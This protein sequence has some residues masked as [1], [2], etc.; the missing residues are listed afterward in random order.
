MSN[1]LINTLL[2]IGGTWLLA[3]PI[4]CA[5]GWLV[6]RVEWPGRRVATAG[7]VFVLLL[8]LYLQAA[9]WDAGLG[10][11]G[12]WTYRTGGVQSP[13]L[14]G[15]TGLLVIHAA[16]AIPWVVMITA[17]GFRWVAGELEDEARLTL[18]LP[19]IFFT[20]ALRRAWPAIWLA[21]I[22]VL[23]LV[24]GEM[25]VTDMYQVRTLAEELYTGFALG[26]DLLA[27]ALHLLPVVLLCAMGMSILVRSHQNWLP[28]V[29]VR[30]STATRRLDSG[31][32]GKWITFAVGL[33]LAIIAGLPLVNLLYQA[34]LSTERAGDG[35]QRWWSPGKLAAMVGQ[36][37]WRFRAEWWG[38]V[39]L[40]SLT[41]LVSVAWGAGLA[42]W[43][44]ARLMRWWL[45]AMAGVVAVAIPGPLFAIAL[46]RLRDW[47][48]ATWLDDA[49]DR[50]LILVAV[51]LAL[52]SVVLV[53]AVC[54][55]AFR[56]LPTAQQDFAQLS[57]LSA[58][59][60]FFAMVLPQRWPVLIAAGLLAW[61]LAAGDVTV[62]ILLLPAGETT[63]A[64]RTF[65]LVHAG[66]DDRL[67]GLTLATSLMFGILGVLMGGCWHG[68]WH[69]RHGRRNHDDTP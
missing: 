45:V 42:W 31:R 3:L 28:P 20:I 39:R 47:L 46:L 9:G 16:Q 25:T 23:A 50:S 41:A 19:S 30:W 54:W 51:V 21:S 62:S 63:V 22:W 37:T 57:G 13:W 58:R 68:R 36:A 18:S 17:A 29:G 48:G 10:R 5:V 8:P 2:A 6:A 52:R 34:G 14:S 33:L 26:D 15:W 44:R 59:R 53:W 40:A 49:M 27:I 61:V 4:G 7:L 60:Q 24:S 1:L 64:I 56:S 12:W 35:W 69:W 66:V 67:A 55:F 43:S 65:Q 38:T 11:Q 32:R